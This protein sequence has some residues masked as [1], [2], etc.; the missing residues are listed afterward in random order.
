[1][2]DRSRRFGGNPFPSGTGGKMNSS[3]ESRNLDLLRSAAVLFVVV[4]HVLLFFQATTLAGINLHAIGHWG[5]LI[6]FVHTSVVL[7]FS[8]ERQI[9]RAPNNPWFGSYYARRVFRIFPLS[10][11]IICAVYLLR[12]PVAHL[13]AG[14][15]QAVHL[16]HS[17]LASN[18]FLVQNV[19]HTDSIIAPLWSL[20][21]EMQ[22]YLALPLLFLIARTSRNAIAVS[23]IWILSVLAAATSLHIHRYQIP[24]VLIYVPCFAAGVIAYKLAESRTFK[25]PFLGWPPV[26]AAITALYLYS[27]SVQTGWICCL[28]VAAAVPQFRDMRVSWFS[29]ACQQVC[30]YSYGIYLTHFIAIWLAFVALHSL[31]MGIRWL[32]F[33]ASLVL[34]SVLLYHTVET[35]MVELG[36]QWTAH[37]NEPK[38]AVSQALLKPS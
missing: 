2:D 14:S 13:H 11:L 32:A 4:F 10:V 6:F 9:S 24:D 3:T 35:P 1:M 25:L 38:P 20:P 28:L 23:G 36:R 7:M 18:L 5:V 31:P 37:W 17:E 21:Y 15:F 26:L 29:K 33:L 27:P 19:T 34:F 8:L 16:N 12:L 30:R 22:M